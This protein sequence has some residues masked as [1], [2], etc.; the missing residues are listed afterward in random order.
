M[1]IEAIFFDVGNTLFFYNYDFLGGL[2]AERF[3]VQTNTAELAEA[4]E[5]VHKA[6]VAEGLAKEGQNVV[7]YESYRRWLR[8]L[9]V[10]EERIPEIIE[11]IRTHPFRHLFWMRM[12][13]GTREMLDWFHERGVKLG[14]ISNAEGQIRRLIEH[15]GLGERFDV[16]ADSAI[17]GSAKPDERIFRFALD[18]LGVEAAHA[19]HVGDLYDVDVVG[20]RRVGLTPILVDREGTASSSECL[21]VSRAVDLPMLPL[22]AGM[23]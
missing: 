8:L 22:F 3:G 4:H 20:A 19:V 9:R 15:A 12:E 11:A 14:V 13:E 6:I 17:V 5:V 1:N 23:K 7:W 10:D 16:I 2:L 18:A 21:T